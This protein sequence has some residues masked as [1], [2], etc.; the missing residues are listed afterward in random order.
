MPE[1]APTSERCERCG[2]RDCSCKICR[3]CKVELRYIHSWG[4]DCEGRNMDTLYQ[5]PK[6]KNIEVR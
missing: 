6:C 5:C 3:D 2:R 1:P 4:G